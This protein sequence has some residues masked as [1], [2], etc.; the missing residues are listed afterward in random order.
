MDFDQIDL[1]DE[2]F[3]D[4]KLDD[5]EALSCQLAE[6]ESYG[7]RRPLAPCIDGVALSDGGAV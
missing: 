3:D 4:I 5:S 6:Y 2:S 7:V 1:L